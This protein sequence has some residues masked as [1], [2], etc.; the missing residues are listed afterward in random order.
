MCA[1]WREQPPRNEIC[2]AICPNVAMYVTRQA[3][4]DDGVNKRYT[5][6]TNQLSRPTSNVQRPGGSLQWGGCH[7]T[8]SAICGDESVVQRLQCQVQR[9][10]EERTIETNL[11]TVSSVKESSETP[12]LSNLLEPKS[13]TVFRSWETSSTPPTTNARPIG[14]KGCTSGR[15]G[16]THR[17]GSV[18]I[19]PLEEL[20]LPPT[21]VDHA[22]PR[23][24]LF[25]LC[26]PLFIDNGIV[27]Q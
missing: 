3:S 15:Q 25:Q 22:S 27:Q 10:A 20:N 19:A 7:S 24:P 4:G 16:V 2:Q 11:T 12:R 9:V 17:A 23:G 13:C 5:N 6:H 1:D 18:P 14:E 26:S 21:H 8:A